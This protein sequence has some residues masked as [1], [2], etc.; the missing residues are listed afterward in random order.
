MLCF[1]NIQ[2]FY[3]L[4]QSILSKNISKVV[5]T[6]SSTNFTNTSERLITRIT[7]IE[8]L[9]GCMLT[10]IHL[11]AIQRSLQNQRLN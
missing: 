5:G 1:R 4:I 2:T 8:F 11:R 3:I 9:L 10:S 6:N 7:E